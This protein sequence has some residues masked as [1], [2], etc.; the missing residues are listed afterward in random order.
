MGLDGMQVEKG[1]FSAIPTL[2]PVLTLKWRGAARGSGVT[3][4]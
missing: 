2:V 3:H 4:A 1:D